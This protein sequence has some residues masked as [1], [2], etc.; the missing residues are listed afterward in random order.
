[1]IIVIFIL[2]YT[3]FDLLREIYRRNYIQLA[4]G[5]LK[6]KY[7]D[8]QK[9]REV[10]ILLEGEKEEKSFLEKVDKLIESSRIRKWM[11]FITSE[12]LIFITLFF[13]FVCAFFVQKAFGIIIF[14]IPVFFAV[15][16]F[17]VLA[18][19]SLS[20]ITYDKIDDQ[21]L[22]YI[23]I[24][25]N[26]S[27]ANSDIVEIMQKSLPYLKEPLGEYTMQFVFECKKG[28]PIDMAF[29]N[30]E[31]KIESLRFKQLLKNL[32]V[33]SKYQA[34]YRE[35]LN[36]SRIIMK[37]YFV[38]KERR[39][40]EVRKSRGAIVTVVIVGLLLFKLVSGFTENYFELLKSTLTG[41]LILGY[42]IF[43]L[44][45]AI[46]KFITIDKINY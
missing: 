21:V 44:L 2:L 28:L 23:N 45:Y 14:S 27:A 43:V 41:N 32:A 10:A 25:E 11:T 17:V 42:N 15:I 22:L 35:I 39:K 7:E 31:N 24:L 20:K 13:A 30:F 3:I 12:I 19:K 8:R 37:Y 6:G 46:Y 36:K 5:N 29:K 1:M 4:L 34:N 18:L 26:L 33:C 40:K 16:I 9:L 38:E